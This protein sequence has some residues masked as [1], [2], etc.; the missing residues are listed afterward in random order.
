MS[1]LLLVFLTVFFLQ[2]CTHA[3]FYVP[4][5]NSV[6]EPMDA[7][8]VA[9]TNMASLDRKHV[10]VGRVAV[11]AW[12]N[13]ESAR[14]ELQKVAAKIG[15][16]AIIGLKTQKGFMRTAASGMAVLVFR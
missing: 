4:R 9:I 8:S 1:K 12:G 2:A 10:L 13:G 3:T 16:N 14:R 6:Y 7:D 5:E 11:L 15:A